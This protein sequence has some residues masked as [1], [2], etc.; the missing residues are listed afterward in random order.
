MQNLIRLGS[1]RVLEVHDVPGL[2]E[3][4]TSTV[5]DSQFDSAKSDLKPAACSGCP[6]RKACVR[7]ALRA[8]G[9]CLFGGMCL[10]LWVGT[11]TLQP[12]LVKAILIVLQKQ[13][14]EERVGN[15]GTAPTREAAPFSDLE[16]L[17]LWLCCV[18]VGM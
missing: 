3:D 4:D 13:I 12:M 5:V 14:D 9:Q 8:R 10:I 15:N 16:P 6:R 18:T 1:K 11:Y 17:H 7:M 2:P